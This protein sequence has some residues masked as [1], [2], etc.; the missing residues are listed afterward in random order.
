MEFANY[1]LLSLHC[2]SY[3]IIDRLIVFTWPKLD[4]NIFNFYLVLPYVHYGVSELFAMF[5][6]IQMGGGGIG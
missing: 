5:N 6:P 4:I 1:S 2:M 3:N